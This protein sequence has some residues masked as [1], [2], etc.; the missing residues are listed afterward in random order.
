V[1]QQLI[2]K[3]ALVAG[4]F[5]SG[6]SSQVTDSTVTVDGGMARND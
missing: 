1:D 5:A 2:G 4:S 3:A 6:A